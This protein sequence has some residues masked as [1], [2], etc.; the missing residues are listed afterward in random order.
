MYADISK[1]PTINDIFKTNVSSNNT[2]KRSSGV[3]GYLPQERASY[4]AKRRQMDLDVSLKGGRFLKLDLYCC[5]LIR[6]CRDY[7]AYCVILI[8]I[9]IILYSITSAANL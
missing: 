6:N 1:M 8:R 4:G 7:D 9:C 5:V 2:I 3:R